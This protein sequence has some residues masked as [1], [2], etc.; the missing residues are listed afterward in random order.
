MVLLSPNRGAF[1]RIGGYNFLSCSN[2]KTTH[3]QPLFTPLCLC[4]EFSI[5]RLL[6]QYTRRNHW[7][8]SSPLF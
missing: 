5:S 7:W 6:L 8:F 1:L 2:F 3:L 4:R